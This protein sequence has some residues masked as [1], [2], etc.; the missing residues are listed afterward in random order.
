MGARG[1]K[2]KSSAEKRLQG[3]RS[4]RINN[5]EPVPDLGDVVPPAGFAD[6]SRLV[7]DSLAPDLERK[8]VLTPWDV[9]TFAAFCDAVVLRHDAQKEIEA[10][11][12]VIEQPV[13]DRHGQLSGHRVVRSQWMLVL[14]DANA[15]VARFGARFG[16]TP[17]DRASLKVGDGKT[18]DPTARLL[19]A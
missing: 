4:E 15:D 11:G 13:F 5:Q 1:T 8:G 14:K 19:S 18:K 2:P 9:E 3:V 6:A 7:W 12:A 17:S 16:L 10:E